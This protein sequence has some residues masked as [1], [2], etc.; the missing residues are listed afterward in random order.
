MEAGRVVEEGPVLEILS[1][2]KSAVTRRFVG[3]IIDDEPAPETLAAL[4]E[5][6]PGRFVK[7][8]FRGT[9]AR[10]PEVFA[11]LLGHDVRFE[12][13][14][15]GIEEVQGATFGNLT[16]ALD[17][18]PDAVDAAVFAVSA[19]VPTKEIAR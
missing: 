17:G 19:I 11:E 16:L 10:Q 7:L 8:A 14:Y 5:R 13:V 9:E 1:D 12:L 6:H 4:R 2:P 18:P 15:G 3:T